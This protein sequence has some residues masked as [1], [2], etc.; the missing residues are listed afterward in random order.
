MANFIPPPAND[1]SQVNYFLPKNLWN[2]TCYLG[3][4]LM[5]QRK[6][7]GACKLNYLM[8]NNTSKSDNFW[9]II[10]GCSNYPWLLRT[11]NSPSLFWI[12][13]YKIVLTFL[14]IGD[15]FKKI[16]NTQYKPGVISEKE[17]SL[18]CHQF[19]LDGEPWT[20]SSSYG[21][22]ARHRHYIA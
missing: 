18:D 13:M 14:D 4:N 8:W 15:A 3:K 12:K 2:N 6:R 9:W 10:F 5:G 20:H 1:A 11:E 19:H 22:H 21:L 17:R 7:C 16:I